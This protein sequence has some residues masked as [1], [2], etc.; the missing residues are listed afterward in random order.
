MNEG[1][2]SNL[3]RMG[4]SGNGYLV[5]LLAGGGTAQHSLTLE[6]DY[7]VGGGGALSG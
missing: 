4:I 1:G 7:S 5:V 2:D 3:D 6:E